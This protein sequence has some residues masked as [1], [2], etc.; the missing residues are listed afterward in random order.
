MAE[1][2]LAV[3]RGRVAKELSLVDYSI[4]IL[5]EEL[6]LLYSLTYHYYRRPVIQFSQ[7]LLFMVVVLA[8]EFEH[9]LG[10]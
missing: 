2:F 7:R 6:I 4:D 5:C 1:N 9:C 10:L 3:H 8:L